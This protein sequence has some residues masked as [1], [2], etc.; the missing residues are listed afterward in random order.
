MGMRLTQVYVFVLL[1]NLDDDALRPAERTRC[2]KRPLLLPGLPGD[3]WTQA[4]LP[5]F[6]GDVGRADLGATRP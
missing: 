1:R 2:C 4:A 3:L 6:T 5:S